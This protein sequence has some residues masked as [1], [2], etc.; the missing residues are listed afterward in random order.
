MNKLKLTIINLD[1]IYLQTE[2]DM[3]I[4]RTTA[5]ELGILHD[6]QPLITNIEISK[7]TLKDD[8]IYNDYAI[9]GGT[10]FISE[11]ECRIITSAIESQSEI[12]IQ[13]A[14]RARDRAKK[15][16]AEPTL[17]DFDIKRA[18]IALKRALNRLDLSE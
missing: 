15:R 7:L 11:N 6:H 9:A 3:L 16:L 1:G 17:P 4:V 5:G 8:E 10:L 18:E 14:K 12:D 2:V 13:R